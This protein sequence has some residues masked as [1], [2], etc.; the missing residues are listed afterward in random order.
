MWKPDDD[1]ET[2][3]VFVPDEI[4]CD[5]NNE[6]ESKTESSACPCLCSCGGGGT[7]LRCTGGR[8]S[9]PSNASKTVR[10]FIYSNN[11]LPNNTL[12][13][14]A[15][16]AFQHA[17]LMIL[18][19]NS[20]CVVESDAFD[21]CR[22]LTYLVLDNNQFVSSNVQPFLGP[23]ATSL[24][25]LSLRSVVAS[26]EESASLWRLFNL[27]LSKETHHSSESERRFG[28][29]F[30]S[31][32]T[33]KLD[34]NFLT[35]INAT[36]LKQ[37]LR[38]SCLRYFSLSHNWLQSDSMEVVLTLLDG[39]EQRI[40]VKNI[41]KNKSLAE[42]PLI[43]EASFSSTDVDM[44]FNNITGLEASFIKALKDRYLGDQPVSPYE[45]Q[46][47]LTFKLK[48][49]NFICNC[50]IN[51]TMCFLF[52]DKGKMIITDWK[53]LTCHQPDKGRLP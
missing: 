13:F 16:A 10:S 51:E 50:S 25:F 47:K 19:S 6:I 27:L 23:S 24:E 26:H 1:P 5:K 30:P 44:T 41:S 48:E 43:E 39:C 33:L 36:N 32:R 2:N 49:N 18:S 42:I 34:G 45:I 17:T 40:N 37:A 22:N 4:D 14:G 20:I 31:L 38:W 53:K 8:F 11:K 3:F 28:N 9:I 46:R 29:T 35:N 12:T 7:E 52:K 21:L 15:L